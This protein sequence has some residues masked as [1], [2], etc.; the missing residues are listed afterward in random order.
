MC[1]PPGAQRIGR[2]GEIAGGGFSSLSAILICPSFSFS[3]RTRDYRGHKPPG[4][5]PHPGPESAVAARVGELSVRQLPNS[6]ARLPP[7]ADANA[8]EKQPR[9][10]QLS[11]YVGGGGALIMA[12]IQEKMVALEC[13]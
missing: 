8:E 11:A 2:Q 5:G 9:Y 10:L 13:V 12:A 6:V 4:P 1:K 3:K 7:P